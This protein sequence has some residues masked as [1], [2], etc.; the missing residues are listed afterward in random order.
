M[1][2]VKVLH[3]LGI[4]DSNKVEVLFL[5]PNQNNIRFNFKGN[6]HILPFI[7]N[8]Y[9]DVHR[10]IVGGMKGESFKVPKIDL[11]FNA[12]C[13][14][15]TNQKSLK[16]ALNI[17]NTLKVP[18]F[19]H[20]EGIMRT[21]RENIYE[22]FK[23][24]DGIVIP[25]TIRAKPKCLSDI[26]KIIDSGEI[27]FPFLFREGGYHAGQNL[28]LIQSLEDIHT[29][30][31]FAFDGRDYY[32]TD[33]INFKSQDGLYRK[34]RVIVIGGKPYPRHLIISDLWNVHAESRKRLM[35]NNPECRREEEKFLSEFGQRDPTIF[36][37]IYEELKLDFLGVDFS[38]DFHGNLIIFEI[39]SCFRAVTDGENQ[40]TNDQDND[41]HKPYIG[42]I[43]KAVEEMILEK[44]EY[45]RN[46]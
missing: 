18:V 40:E 4:D 14:P 12:I 32:L 45:V 41:Y 10:V 3:I 36:R 27:R 5:S 35:D 13:N 15:D 21:G 26:M 33:F 34:C 25:K 9:F 19:N 44:A 38:F 6:V 37:K 7:D 11:I 42:N 17:V 39:N 29:L 22:L 1:S 43:K 16:V 2:K 30:E 31:K 23:G 46:L 20:P 28:E 24:F 8:T